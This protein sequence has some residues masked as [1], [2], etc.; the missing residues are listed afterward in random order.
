M[1]HSAADFLLSALATLGRQRSVPA[2]TVLFY[3]GEKPDGLVWAWRG[4]LHRVRFGADGEGMV[5]QRCRRGPVAEGSLFSRHYHCDGVA[6]AAT[7]LI[8]I[9]RTRFLDAFADPQFGRAY[10]QWLSGTVRELRTH[11]ER[12]SLRRA[13]DRVEHYL[14]EHVS[15]DYGRGQCSLKD[16]A[17]QLG[18]SHESLYRTLASMEADGRIMRDGGS[19]RLAAGTRAGRS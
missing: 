16:W 13:P 14:N 10:A 1:P 11:C 18:L 3:H 4:E 5:L 17:T 19:V 2:G 6:A 8:A 7:T 15:F 12:L 9:P